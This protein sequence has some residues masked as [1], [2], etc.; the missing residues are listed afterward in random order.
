MRIARSAAAA[1]RRRA[2]F[3]GH[4]QNRLSGPGLAHAP[5]I[6]E[7]VRLMPPMWDIAAMG[8]SPGT[9]TRTESK[10]S[11][12]RSFNSEGNS[13]RC[14]LQVSLRATSNFVLL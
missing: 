1:G 11:K 3:H 5:D 14:G 4:S 6:P 12:N 7:G 9:S 13:A 8:I 2:R 10:P